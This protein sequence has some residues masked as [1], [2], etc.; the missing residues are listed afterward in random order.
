MNL[1][2]AMELCERHARHAQVDCALSYGEPGYS[3]SDAPSGILFADW[4]DCPTWLVAGLERRGFALE[5]S[6][7]WIVS[8][9]NNSKAYRTS[10]NSY[11]WKPY[12]VITERGDVYGGDEIESGDQAEW[13]V[14]EYLLNDPTRCNTF[15]GLNLADH[16]FAQFNG[17]FESG[18]RS[19]QNDNPKE[20][21]ARIN[22]ERPD[23]DVVFSLDSVGQFDMNWTVWIRPVDKG[24]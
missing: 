7:E 22:R 21:F 18:W 14:N 16:G 3:D 9:E 23:C 15:R 11:G 5:W 19:G 2:T 17:M 12:Y 20:V 4:N 10:P 6:D 1:A 13:Y 8:Y 24:E